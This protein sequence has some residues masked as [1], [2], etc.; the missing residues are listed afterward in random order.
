MKKEILILIEIKDSA[1][2]LTVLV[3]HQIYNNFHFALFR[4]IYF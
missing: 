4:I 2:I 1:A 3:Y